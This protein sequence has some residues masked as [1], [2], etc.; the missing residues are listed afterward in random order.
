[1]AHRLGPALCV[2]TW[3]SSIF[4]CRSNAVVI[5]ATWQFL[6]RN[7]G[8]QF[9]IG[10][11]PAA[12]SSERL[13]SHNLLFHPACRSSTFI[14]PQENNSA[15]A[16]ATWQFR[17]ASDSLNVLLHPNPSNEGNPAD[18][19]AHGLGPAL[20]SHLAFKRFPVPLKCCGLS[21]PPGNFL[22]I[23]EKQKFPLALFE[24]LL[25]GGHLF[26]PQND[27]RGVHCPMA[28]DATR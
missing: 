12:N 20:C 27:G 19:M 11:L 22:L 2:A 25:P 23:P 28:I 1:M 9:K 5:V 26:A 7:I 13:Q 16:L 24:H 21:L 8:R 18:V 4:L 6:M 10:C 15:G 17:R 14:H 3:R